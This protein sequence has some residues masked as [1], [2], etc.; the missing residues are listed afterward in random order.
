M[1]AQEYHMTT[2]SNV[3]GAIDIGAQYG[4]NVISYVDEERKRKKWMETER[5]GEKVRGRIKDVQNF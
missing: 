4:W 1:Q 5:D 3:S 2:R